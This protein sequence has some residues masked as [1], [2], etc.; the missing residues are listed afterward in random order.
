MDILHIEPVA[1]SSTAMIRCQ[2]GTH[3][4]RVV[5]ATA[6]STTMN[7]VQ[8]SGG[9]LRLVGARLDCAASTAANPV[10]KSGGTLQL[11][12]VSLISDGTRD[13]IEAASPQTV[14]CINAVAN[15]AAD[16]TNVTC[17]G[18]GLFVDTAIA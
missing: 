8:I 6:P 14:L 12:G 9:T 16:V 11:R 7:G 4:V 17:S 5:D 15:T 3:N 2:A 13:S 1:G 10:L 18:T